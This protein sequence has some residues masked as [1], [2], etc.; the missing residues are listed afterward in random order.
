METP[1]NDFVSTY[2]MTNPVRF[3]MPGHKGYD[4]FHGRL[5]GFEADI[6]K[7]DITEVKGTENL[8]E[9]SEANASEIFGCPTYYSTEGSSLCIRAMMSLLLKKTGIRTVVAPGQDS[10]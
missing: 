2:V 3:H 9:L 4:L 1:L 10:Y 8:I 5:Y 7:F 6:T